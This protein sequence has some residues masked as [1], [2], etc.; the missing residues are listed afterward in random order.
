MQ[1]MDD[2]IE[3]QELNTKAVMKVLC[4]CARFHEKLNEFLHEHR[5]ETLPAHAIQKFIDA[6]HASEVNMRTG[7]IITPSEKIKEVKFFPH[8]K[9]QFSVETSPINYLKDPFVRL[10]VIIEDYKGDK[11]IIDKDVDGI[12][13]SDQGYMNVLNTYEYLCNIDLEKINK[14]SKIYVII[15]SLR[16]ENIK[17]MLATLTLPEHTKSATLHY[18]QEAQK[19]DKI[20][21]F[22]LYWEVNC[23][24]TRPTKKE[25]KP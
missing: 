19:F 14:Y 5:W 16:K 7:E 4:Q 24:R 22:E 10:E 21:A 8:T 23:W 15:K 18:S 12:S 20:L 11:V 13:F 2:F 6:Y 9:I 17:D 25:Y 3:A 1:T